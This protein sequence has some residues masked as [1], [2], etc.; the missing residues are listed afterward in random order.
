MGEWIGITEVSEILGIS[1]NTVK[2]LIREGKIPAYEVPGLLV[3]R[4]KR[5]EIEELIKPVRP[6]STVG[7]DKSRKK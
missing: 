3:F 6:K 5:S 4:F 2:K 1:T 7:R